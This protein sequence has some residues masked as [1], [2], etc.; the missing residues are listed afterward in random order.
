MSTHD[1]KQAVDEMGRA[2]E[3]FKSYHDEALGQKADQ[4]HVDAL[5]KEAQEKANAAVSDLSEKLDSK[6]GELAALRAAVQRGVGQA[7]SDMGLDPE[8]KARK[9][10]G[11]T[12][13]EE[14]ALTPDAVTD[15]AK[16][17]SG[18]LRRGEAMPAEVAKAMQVGRDPEGGF[19]VEP[20]T[21]GRIVSKIYETSAVRQVANVTTIGTDALEGPLDLDEP[22]SG[23]VGETEDRPDTRSPQVGKWRIP[24]HEQYAQPRISQKMLDDAMVDVEQ[25]LEDKVARKLARGENQAFVK[26]NGSNKP[27]G[28]LSYDLG[29]P[30]GTN[31]ER[32]PYVETG[33]D[34]AFSTSNGSGGDVLIDAI[35]GLKEE[36]RTNATWAMNRSVEA[37]VRKLKDGQGNYLW[38]PD[39]SQ[40]NGRAILGANIINFEDMPG[41]ASDSLSIAVADWEEAYQIVDRVG[42]RVLRDPYTGKPF[43]KFYTTKRVGGGVVNFEAIKLVKFAA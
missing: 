42:I 20:D 32:I 37:E 10:E 3:Q 27:R 7:G 29:D 16:A 34:G 43:V 36:Y 38:Q 30:D 11:I 6:A 18:Y 14:G 12:G 1:V 39:F 2:F 5:V 13:Q 9:F 31:W 40:R 35:Y 26:G 22:D 33:A 17:F 21:D 19:W 41:I 8:A 25:W 23:W 24:V 15:Y 4:S 28:F